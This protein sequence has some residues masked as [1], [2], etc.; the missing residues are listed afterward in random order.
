M[1]YN[2]STQED[3]SALPIACAI[4]PMTYL[5]T[6]DISV[7]FQLSIKAMEMSGMQLSTS[8]ASQ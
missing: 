2:G 7:N 6:R 5:H 1:S 3:N 8:A 4:R